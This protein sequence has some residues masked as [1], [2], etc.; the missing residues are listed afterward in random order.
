[1]GFSF[2]LLHANDLR[3]SLLIIRPRSFF[4]LLYVGRTYTSLVYSWYQ[5]I[6]HRIAV[7]VLFYAEN[8]K[9]P[10]ENNI[11]D[12]DDP[13]LS[14]DIAMLPQRCRSTVAPLLSLLMWLHSHSCY[15]LRCQYS[16]I[17]LS[18][19]CSSAITPQSLRS[20]SAVAPLSLRCRSAVAPLSLR[21]RSAVAPLSLRC[22]SAVAPL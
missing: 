15:C 22:R 2:Q 6:F 12:S 3:S 20:R 7:L 18:L 1:M 21:C 16:V 17:P 10:D 19:R 4:A 11:A 13:P 14:T 9:N 8:K 5:N